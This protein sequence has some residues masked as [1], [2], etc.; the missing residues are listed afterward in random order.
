MSKRFPGRRLS[1]FRLAILIAIISVFAT[2]GF[3]G[4]RS[5]QDGQEAGRSE[6]WFGG[7]VDVTATPVHHFETLVDPVDRNVALGFVVASGPDECESSWGG[8]YTLAEARVALEL[9]RRV[10]RLKQSG[11]Q[12]VVSF[13]GEANTEL[14]LAC[15]DPTELSAQYREVIERYEPAAIDLDIEGEALLDTASRTRRAEAI[16]QIQG[17]SDEPIPVWLTLPVGADGMTADGVA[18]VQAF[19]DAGARIAGVNAM[20]M[21]FTGETAANDPAG[22]A[23]AALES[24]HRQLSA[25][26]A[27]RGEDYG[28]QTLWR[29]LGATP[30]IGQNDVEPEVFTLDDARRLHAFATEVGLGRVSLWSANRDRTCAEAYADLSVVSDSCSGV[31][32]GDER[33]SAIL[34]AG[35]TG[36]PN[37]IDDTGAATPTLR[38]EDIEDDPESSPYPI[39]DATASYPADTRVVWRRNVYVAKWWSTSI[40]PDD[41]TLAA[42]DSPWRLVGP[43]LPG[44]TPLPQ[45]SLP[46][47]F[48]P[49]WAPTVIYHRGDRTMLDGVAYEAKWW[50]LD[51][52]PASGQADPGASPWRVL[53]QAEIESLL[54]G[55]D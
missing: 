23:I 46:E 22:M 27:D 53:T 48:Y 28:G 25:I 10:A 15:D 49:M 14:A 33:F 44:E 29:M 26:Y 21:N 2:G 13:G 7:Y 16:A 9:D 17:E 30:M 39:W 45:L 24:A 41:P 12:V 43:V 35:L 55:E 18:T 37:G 54:D 11:G 42:A 20:T 52:N 47:D 6:P 31:V 1:P 36:T 34:G 51:D 19:L 3:V 38:P 8:Y 32:Q 50:T 4:V 40:Q 5:W